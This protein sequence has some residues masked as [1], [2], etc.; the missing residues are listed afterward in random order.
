MKIYMDVCCYNRPFDDQSQ[1]R[2]QIESNA[3][4]MILNLCQIGKCLIYGSDA[5]R[6]EIMNNKDDIKRQKVEKLYSIASEHI[7]S[8]LSINSRAKEINAT[9]FGV[10][11]SLHLAYS[12]HAKVDVFLTTDDAL[13]KKT[14]STNVLE[15]RVENPVKWILEVR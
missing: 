5:I 13:I 12:E 1:D 3:V 8:N 11:D 2:I 15:V 9:G 4:L 7:V 10:L 6:Y 14:K